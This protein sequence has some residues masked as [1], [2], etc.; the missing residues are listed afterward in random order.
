MVLLKR[1]GDI[2]LA[3]VYTTISSV[4]NRSSEMNSFCIYVHIIVVIVVPSPLYIS[5]MLKAPSD[6]PR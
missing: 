1:R 2:T 6:Y 4:I 5:W 3:V